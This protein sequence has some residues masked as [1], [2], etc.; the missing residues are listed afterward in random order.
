MIATLGRWDRGG[1]SAS[2]AFQQALTGQ[3]VR[4]VLAAG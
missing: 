2:P 1:D 4:G 3:I